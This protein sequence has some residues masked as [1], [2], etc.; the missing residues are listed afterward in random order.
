[1]TSQ[2]QLAADTAEI[3]RIVATRI[4]GLYD[5]NIEAAM[6][7]VAADILCFDLAPPLAARGADAYRGGLEAWFPT[8][9]G[10][11]GYKATRL[12]VTLGGDVA[13]TTA[14]NRIGGRKTD[15]EI[16]EVW[17]R[18]TAGFRKLDGQWTMTHEHV[19]VPYHMDG[20][21]KAAVDLS[22]A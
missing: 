15:G 11:I 12:E 17:V 4:A 14:I 20:S 16:I 13:F 5:K 19:S 3:E 8:W 9:D 1:M 7:H 2:A 6:A 22:P 21:V 18:A 10:P